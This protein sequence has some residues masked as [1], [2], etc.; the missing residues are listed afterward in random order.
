[1]KFKIGQKIAYIGDEKLVEAII[2]SK[3]E[4]KEIND[5]RYKAIINGIYYNEEKQPYFI[6]DLRTGDMGWLREKS[7]IPMGK[8]TKLLFGGKD[9]KSNKI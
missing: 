6:K 1:M 7:I 3:E 4:A 5:Y 2:I 9:D 8:A